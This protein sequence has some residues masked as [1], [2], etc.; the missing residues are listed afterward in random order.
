M[1]ADGTGT[2]FGPRFTA[3]LTLA[4][5]PVRVRVSTSTAL[6]GALAKAA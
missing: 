6:A 1:L 5:A 2:V 4:L 3:A